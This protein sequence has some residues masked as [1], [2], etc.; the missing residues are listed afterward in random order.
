ML[1]KGER[2]ANQIPKEKKKIGIMLTLTS[3]SSESGKNL[4]FFPPNFCFSKILILSATSVTSMFL[5]A[6]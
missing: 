4:I 5:K 2:S 6:G 1:E 3:V